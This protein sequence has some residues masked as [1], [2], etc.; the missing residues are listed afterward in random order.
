MKKSLLIAW[1]ALLLTL[2]CAGPALADGIIIPIPRPPRPAPPLRSLAIKYHRVSVAIQDQVAVTHVDQVFL[3]ESAYDMEG[4]YIFP[5]PEGASISQFAMWVDG[6]KLEAQVLEADEAREIYEEIVRQ[7]RDPALLEYA[8]RNAFRARIYPIPA[9]G[10]KR[11]ELEYTEVLPLDQGLVRYTYPLNTEK[12]STRPL[13][14]VSVTVKIASRQAIQA[15]YSPSHEVAVQRPSDTQA[16]AVYAEKDATP[17]RDFTLYYAVSANDLGVNLLSYKEEGEDGFFLL[18]AAP[19]AKVEARQVIAK[20]VFLI[21]DISG[22]MRGEKLTQAMAA[23]EYILSNLNPSDRFNVVAFSTGTRHYARG[24]RP[25]KESAAAR[26]FV[27]DLVAGGG[28]NI[29]QALDETLSQ[30]QTG[31]PQMILFL[32]DGLPTEGQRDPDKIIARVSELAG[33]DVRL[34]CFGVGYDV[35]TT[36][37][38]TI[39]QRHHGTT[40]Y[41]RP[42][43]DIEQA[44]SS[45]YSKISDPVLADVSLD[46]GAVRV[47]EVYPNPLPDV[48]TG[49]QLVVVGRYREA[50]T[51]TLTLRGVVNGQVMSYTYPDIRFRNQGGADFIPRLWAT[52]KIGHLLTE[53]RLHGS[54]AELVDEIVALGTRYGI[55]TPYTSFLVDES[56]DT[57][58]WRDQQNGAAP[59]PTAVYRGRGKPDGGVGGGGAPAVSAAPASG[60]R[61]VE[62]SIAQ[63]EMREADRAAAPEGEQVRAVGDKTFALRDGVWTDTTYDP[64]TMTPERIAFGSERYFEIVRERPEWGKY[65]ALGEQVILVWQ[66]KAY[67]IGASGQAAPQPAA[68]ANAPRPTPTPKPS[69]W[70]EWWRGLFD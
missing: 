22:S 47:E 44:V 30:T 29:G 36:L 43:E 10:E 69:A 13:E 59:L 28:T 24:L 9:H 40:V 49:G 60:E 53:I 54:E 25:A 17:D 51:A 3:N 64:K 26:T 70:D 16:E 15:V 52:R 27:R 35:N 11:I 46:F 56:E 42:S 38:D 39:A 1:F 62:K 45:F 65:L 2:A 20:D 50:G 63:Q 37:L 21:L 14:D 58:A 66:G 12:F 31:R 34:F 19:N 7:Q 32:T 55:A 67:H 33:E 68:N 48:F 23:A 41:V 6:H 61:E 4:E 57:V 5:L 8:G 18:L